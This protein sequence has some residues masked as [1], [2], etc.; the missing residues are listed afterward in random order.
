M[1]E[2]G[3]AEVKGI[4]ILLHR[5]VMCYFTGSL[6]ALVIRSACLLHPLF[7]PKKEEKIGD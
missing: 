3:I 1:Q 6:A 4:F 2:K 7:T 5:Y